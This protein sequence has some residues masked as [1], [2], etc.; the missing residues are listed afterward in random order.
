VKVILSRKGFDSSNGKYPS[1][2]LP[3]GKML[4]L[5]IPISGDVPYCE[6]DAPGGKTYE[7]VIEELKVDAHIAGKGA[8]MDPDL[9]RTARD[10][11]P[12]WRPA[13]GQNDKAQKLLYKYNVSEGDLFLFFGWFQYTKKLSNQLRYQRGSPKIHAIFGYLEVGE[14]YHVNEE[15]ELPSW[16]DYH[17]H[18]ISPDR[19]KMKNNTIY[20]ATPNLSFHPSYPGGGVFKFDKQLQLT[21]KG[22]SKSRWDLDPEIFQHLTFSCDENKRKEDVWTGEYYQSPQTFC[23]EIVIPADE[24]E[25]VTH[26]AINLIKESRLWSD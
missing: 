23:Q 20:V 12:G 26:W 15:A 11:S 24:D 5:P 8:H 22:E 3:D 21:K 4:S 1:P 14:I 25:G 18:V 2:I 13:F 10:R 6:L 7:Q 9:V 16:L 19:G 17:P